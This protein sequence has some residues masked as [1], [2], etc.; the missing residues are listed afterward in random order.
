MQSAQARTPAWGLRLPKPCRSLCAAVPF[1]VLVLFASSVAQ[2]AD[3][4]RVEEDWELVLDVVSEAK[5][6]PQFETLMS[7]FHYNDELTVFFCR[8]TWNYR[9]LPS[10]APGGFQLQTCIGDLVLSQKGYEG[11]PFSTAGETVTWTQQLE[12]SADRAFFKIKNGQST[13]WGAFGGSDLQLD[14]YPHPPNLNNYTPDVSVSKSGITYGANR[15]ISLRIKAIRRYGPGG[16]LLSVDSTPR[17][18]HQR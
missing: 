8:V 5:Q 15:V 13:T 9:E 16:E 14:E 12:S 2:S 7:P 3:V 17:V 6:A 1:S 10:Y 11:E 4:V 18:V